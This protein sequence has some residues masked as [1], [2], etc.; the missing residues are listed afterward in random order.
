MSYFFRPK[1]NFRLNASFH[2]TESWTSS[3]FFKLKHIDKKKNPEVVRCEFSL[4]TTEN[5]IET[6][7]SS[8]KRDQVKESLND[9]I[10]Y[11]NRELGTNIT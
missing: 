9:I 11:F 7:F 3:F 4:K 6:F 1:L 5:Q 8:I 10:R 2:T